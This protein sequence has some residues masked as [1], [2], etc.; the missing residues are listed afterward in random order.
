[1]NNTC[2][3]SKDDRQELP[4]PREAYLSDCGFIL[5]LIEGYEFDTCNDIGG[6]S[7]STRSNR[8]ALP[9]GKCM[10]C[11]NTITNPPLKGN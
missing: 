8:L 5:T 9:G 2:N 7:F 4:Y 10:K 1:M 3:Y 11:G 6:K